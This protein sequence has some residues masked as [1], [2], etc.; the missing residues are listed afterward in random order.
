MKSNQTQ[1][2]NIIV[3]ATHGGYS[4]PEILI[5]KLTQEFQERRLLRNF[6]D[7]ATHY[8]L[9]NNIPMEN[10]VVANFSRALGDPNRDKQAHDFFRDYDFGGNKI[11]ATPLTEKEKRQLILN[12]YDLYHQSVM[13]VLDD[14]ERKE[15][16]IIVFDIH[17]TG[18]YLL[19]KT[20]GGD[21]KKN[22]DFP[23]INLG[24][25]YGT[26]CDPEI[27]KDCEYLIEKYFGEKPSINAPYSGGFVTTEYGKKYNEQK[28]NSEKFSRNVIQLELNRSLYMEEHEQIV[29]LQKTNKV[30]E[31]LEKVIDEL[32]MKYV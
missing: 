15:E 19:G 2:K 25:K 21:R 3:L 28:D 1:N 8:I 29:D 12:F 5:P 20:K 13:N 7:F 32:G 6:S 27:I 18:S 30:R 22:Q 4:I 11:W 9:P 16:K 24:N 10:T 31:K 23:L 26:S 14:V 17:D